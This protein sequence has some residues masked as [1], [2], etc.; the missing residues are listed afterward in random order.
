MW[1]KRNTQTLWGAGRIQIGIATIDN[2]IEAPSNIK[3]VPPYDS[4]MPLL[5]VYLKGMKSL[6]Q[7]D[8]CTAMLTAAFVHAYYIVANVRKQ[9][10]HS[11]VNK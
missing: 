7:R 8:I 3:M 11:R 2:R 10:V 9:T 4:L 5:G 6:S 1:R